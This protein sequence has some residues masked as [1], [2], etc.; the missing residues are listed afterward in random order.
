LIERT[1]VA[2]QAAGPVALRTPAVTA[3]ARRKGHGAFT[4][5][6]LRAL[7]EGG[8]G[9]DGQVVADELAQCV[10]ELVPEVTEKKFKHR[11]IPMRELH[12]AAFPLAAPPKK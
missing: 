11:Q 12:G 5:A 3:I 7:D 1:R 6:L 2:N 8:Y 9:A 10:R 4:Y